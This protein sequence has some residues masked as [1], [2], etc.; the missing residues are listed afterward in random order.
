MNKLLLLPLFLLVGCTTDQQNRAAEIWETPIK[1]EAP[2]EGEPTPSEPAPSQGPTVGDAV[3][4]GI[5]S[6]VGAVT[7]NPVLGIALGGLLTALTGA[8]L[9]KKK[10]K[11]QAKQPTV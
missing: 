4:D 6:G 2:V 3:I 7:G 8:A 10:A 11:D 1:S 5:S 9:K